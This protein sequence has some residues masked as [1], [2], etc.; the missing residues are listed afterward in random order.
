MTLSDSI[1]YSGGRFVRYDDARVG[2]LTHALNY[3]TG[4]FEG[5]RGYWQ[6]QERELYL[7]QLREHYERLH[8][9][10]GILLMD[11]PKTVDELIEIT[12]ELCARNRF[13][14]NVYIR[15]LV[16]KAAEEIGVRLDG[17]QDGFAI[18][19]VPFDKYYDAEAGLRTG[20]SSWRR[21]DDTMAPARAKVSGAYINSALAK[22]EALMNG[23]DEG[24]MLSHDG[25]VAEGSAANLF[26]VRAGRLFTPDATQNVLEGITRRTVL[27]LAKDEL[28]L[29][30]V[31]RALDRSELYCADELFLTGTAAGITF[32]N[33][34]D[35]RP[36]GD[37]SKG[38]L[39]RRLCELF[40]RATSGRDPNY[41]HALTPTY[42]RRKVGAA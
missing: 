15:P 2:L 40:E 13:E 29:E 5:I 35:H 25:H 1:V 6:P 12:V 17:V 26:L 16:Y 3:G 8:D 30:I 28:A 14:E 7:W 42:A 41:R 32:V 37:G 4:C 21:I 23:F 19:V 20:V 18:V 11:L 31:E 39:T 38:P 10:A 34:V 9:S 24:I 27:A 33:S 36:I 22:S